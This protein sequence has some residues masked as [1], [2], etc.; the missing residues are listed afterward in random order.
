[1]LNTVPSRSRL[2]PYRERYHTLITYE[3]D[4]T[5]VKVVRKETA[6]FDWLANTGGFW[7]FFAVVLG[8]VDVLDDVQLYQITDLL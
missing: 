7:A 8:L 3:V 5:N 6:F 4:R 1:M 2:V